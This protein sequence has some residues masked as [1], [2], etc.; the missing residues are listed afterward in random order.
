MF[1]ET[2]KNRIKV[3]KKTQQ[4]HKLE[5]KNVNVQ[6]AERLKIEAHS[7]PQVT[8]EAQLEEKKCV[9]V[10]KEKSAEAEANTG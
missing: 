4:Q 9:T 6:K 3:T 7:G 10:E 8:T 5:L 1:V 2:K